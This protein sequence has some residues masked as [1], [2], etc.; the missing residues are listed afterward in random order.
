MPKGYFY[1][2]TLAAFVA[3]L[4]EVPRIKSPVGKP[5][6]EHLA[7]MIE[8]M[9]LLD[10]TSIHDAQEASRNIGWMLLA[11]EMHGFW[12]SEESRRLISMD[13]KEGNTVPQIN[14]RV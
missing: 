1:A 9:A 10:Q 5:T 2:N 3:E 14:K 8:Q 7:W 4:R 11:A 6:R 13:V 12:G